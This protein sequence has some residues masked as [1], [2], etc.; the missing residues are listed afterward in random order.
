MYC[1]D[2]IGIM[3][4]AK[5]G[6]LLQMPVLSNVLINISVNGGCRESILCDQRERGS[7]SAVWKRVRVD[8]KNLLIPLQLGGLEEFDHA[9]RDQPRID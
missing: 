9:N 6:I 2:D 5:W 3:F 1:T 8:N 4:N 7:Q